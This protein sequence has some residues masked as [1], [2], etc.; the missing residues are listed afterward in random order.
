MFEFCLAPDTSGD[1]T[2]CDN[3]TCIIVRFNKDSL[4][5]GAKRPADTSQNPTE[6]SEESKAKKAKTQEESENL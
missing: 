1:G 6:Y 3:M 5:S 4:A 2:G